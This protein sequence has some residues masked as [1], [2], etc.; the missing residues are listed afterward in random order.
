[1]IQAHAIYQSGGTKLTAF[2]ATWDIDNAAFEAV[3]S[4]EQSGYYLEAAQ[5]VSERVGVFVRHENWDNRAGN[6][7]D[8]END[9]QTLGVNFW[10]HEN[11][12]IKADMFT[13]ETFDT[14]TST[15][16]EKEGFN[17]GIGYQF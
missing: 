16:G 8:S 4:D 2:Y 13:A 1:M 9:Q 6:A 7:A 5:K 11:V 12:V 14:G 17:L 15:R 10:P 3:G